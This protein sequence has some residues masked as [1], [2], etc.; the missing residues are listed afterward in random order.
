MTFSKKFL[1]LG[2]LGSLIA[3]GGAY[4]ATQSVTAS[5]SFD[6]AVTL[7]GLTNINFGTVQ[8]GI[9]GATYTVVASTGVVNPSNGGVVISTTGQTA[10]QL[11]IAGSSS[12][13]IAISTGGYTANGGV[14]LSGATC[15]Y[16]GAT[17]VPCDTGL[18]SQAAP[19]VGKLLKLGVAAV[20]DG[21]ASAG[22][23]ATPSFTV[24]VVYG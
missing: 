21:T 14:T 13:S 1:A 2:L 12:Q 24:T 17:A 18:T 10:G 16:N 20:S 5:V 15:S 4:A 11:T 23:T 8:A 3:S 7:S 6:S 22:S 9:V 19:G